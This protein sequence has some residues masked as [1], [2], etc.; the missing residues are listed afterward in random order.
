MF[1][2][3]ISDIGAVVNEETR[4]ITVRAE[5]GNDDQRLKPGMFADVDILLNGMEQTLVVPVA[6]VLEDGRQKIVF[7]K[8]EDRFVQRHVE[9]GA[10]DG[11][12]MQV[13]AGL[14]AGEEVVIEGNHQLRSVLRADVLHAAHA[15]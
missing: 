12:H 9:T 5:V 1:E 10:V 11:N 13:L 3:T 6:A 14:V 7:V 2:G 15:H 8:E 4:T